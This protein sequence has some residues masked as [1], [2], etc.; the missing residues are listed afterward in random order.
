[1]ETPFYNLFGILFVNDNTSN[2]VATIAKHFSQYFKPIIALNAEIN[3]ASFR[4]RH[5]VY[6][7]ELKFEGIRPDGIET[8]EF[9]NFSIACLIKHREKKQYAGTVR[10]VRPLL[11]NQKLPIEKY[12]QH[13]LEGVEKHPNQFDPKHICEISRLAV[14]EDFRRRQIDK[15]QG[16]ETGVINED[17]YSE[18]ELRCFPFIAIGLYLSATALCFKLD[19]EHVFVMMEPRLARSM[20]FIGISFEKLGA[21]VEYHGKR[22][23]YYI[24]PKTL[25]TTLSPGFLDLLN[26]IIADL[27]LQIQQGIDTGLLV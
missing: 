14:P 21:T 18:N 11:G 24:H 17:T 12:C 6:C 8:D 26:N 16:A 23:P 9:D 15:F 2:D 27:D 7:E 19:I 5:N 4:I 3:E 25:L 22:A 13:A 1:M 20:R 10:M